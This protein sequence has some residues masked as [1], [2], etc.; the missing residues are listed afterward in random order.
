M[1]DVRASNLTSGIRKVK[2]MNKK[3]DFEF[4]RKTR[5]GNLGPVRRGTAPS[6]ERRGV[7]PVEAN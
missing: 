5:G 4:K 6:T 3:N 2:K 1:R 7:A